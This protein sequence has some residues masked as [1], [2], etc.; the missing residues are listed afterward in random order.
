MAGL[1]FVL[2][3]RGRARLGT[4]FLF[5]QSTALSVIKD[6][7]PSQEEFLERG[8]VSKRQ[9]QEELTVNM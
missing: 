8:Q 5:S 1:L 9:L 7:L 4:R 2:L 6:C 3:G